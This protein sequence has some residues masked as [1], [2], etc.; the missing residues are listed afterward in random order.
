MVFHKA[1]HLSQRSQILDLDRRELRQLNARSLVERVI[2]LLLFRRTLSSLR[3][4]LPINQQLQIVH[5]GDAGAGEESAKD[6]MGCV[7]I[8]WQTNGELLPVMRSSKL[9]ALRIVELQSPG[10]IAVFPHPQPRETG[11]VPGAQKS[12]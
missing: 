7:R 9:L 11:D 4:R 2:G 3:D 12:A 8:E 1:P 10:I 6:Q 5:P